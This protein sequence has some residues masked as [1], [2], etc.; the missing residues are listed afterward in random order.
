MKKL[1]GALMLGAAILFVGACGD[2]KKPAEKTAEPVKVEPATPE[3]AA[4]APTEPAQKNPAEA[5]KGLNEAFKAAAAAEGDTPCEQAYNGAKALAEKFAKDKAAKI[6]AKDEFIAACAKLPE[7]MQKCMT[8]GYAMT[9]REE[10]K[11]AKDEVDPKL[12]EG[13]KKLKTN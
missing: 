12:L 5:L 7:T 6:P 11:K 13:I 1:I 8:I 2:D 10:C 9:H 4:P 3:K